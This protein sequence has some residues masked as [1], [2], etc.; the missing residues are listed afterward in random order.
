MLLAAAAIILGEIS[1]SE[2][3]VMKCSKMSNN[4]L[5]IKGGGI[6]RILKNVLS[7]TVTVSD[8]C[9]QKTLRDT[10]RKTHHI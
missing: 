4:M 1:N 7:S 6:K 9:R 2:T 10:K 8:N 5:D 3:A